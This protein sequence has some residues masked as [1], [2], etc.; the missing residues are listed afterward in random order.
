MQKKYSAVE[1][2]VMLEKAE[3]EYIFKV[4]GGYGCGLCGREI[5]INTSRDGFMKIAMIS[6]MNKHARNGEITV[7]KK[8]DIYNLLNL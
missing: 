8:Y 6:H 1:M 7:E 5:T 4:R 2:M 3:S